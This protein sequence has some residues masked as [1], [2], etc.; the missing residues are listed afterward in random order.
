MCFFCAGTGYMKASDFLVG[1]TYDDICGWCRG[2]KTGRCELCLGTGRK[3]CTECE[4]YKEIKTYT[5]M[6]ILFKNHVS[7]HI[8]DYSDMPRHLLKKV[9]GNMEF[10]QVLNQVSP[11]TSYPVNEV[12]NIST[13]IVNEHKE[14]FPN[15]NILKQRQQLRAVPVT[16]VHYT[17]ENEQGCYWIYGLE[18]EVY[19]PEYPQKGCWGCNIL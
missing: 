14:A 13:I 6:T 2:Y 12:N 4:G 11:I 19:A 8:L 7:R 9:N 5:E 15:G 1:R 10:Q 3:V 16:E 17:W 18:R